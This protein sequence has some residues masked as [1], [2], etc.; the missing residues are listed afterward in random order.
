MNDER[1]EKMIDITMSLQVEIENGYIGL[2]VGPIGGIANKIIQI[3]A[4]E[5]REHA[6]VCKHTHSHTCHLFYTV[7]SLHP[8]SE[9]P[10]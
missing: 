5:K 1:K 6:H 2:W 9:T 4:I 7:K 3:F 8:F 10:S